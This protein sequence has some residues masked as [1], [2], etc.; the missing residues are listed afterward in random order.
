MIQLL[1]PCA[2]A[3]L[4][5][6]KGVVLRPQSLW[7]FWGIT[8]V[9][10]DLVPSPYPAWLFCQLSLLLHCCHCS[11]WSKCRVRGS[12]IRAEITWP[13]LEVADWRW[14]SSREGG[15]ERGGAARWL[16]GKMLVELDCAVLTEQKSPWLPRVVHL[17][18]IYLFMP[19][20]NFGSLLEQLMLG[21]RLLLGR[22]NIYKTFHGE[23]ALFFIT[24]VVVVVCLVE[25]QCY[26]NGFWDT[27]WHK[28]EKEEAAGKD[29]VTEERWGGREGLTKWGRGPEKT[30]QPSVYGV[31]LT[32][33]KR[34]SCVCY[35]LSWLS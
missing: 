32:Y 35:P 11:W 27:R 16:S 25:C 3:A 14:P 4:G 17:L 7:W 12:R 28:L 5:I 31:C 19:Q 23:S 24:L 18:R 2:T 20:R 9:P 30:C 1:C 13:T 29:K 21:I 34:G 33:T 6:I 8:C 22:L 10:V 26:L 15:L